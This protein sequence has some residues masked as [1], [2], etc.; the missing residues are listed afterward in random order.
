M[1]LSCRSEAR[2]GRQQGDNFF[3]LF[4]AKGYMVLLALNLHTAL[5]PWWLR[6]W[7]TGTKAFARAWVRCGLHEAERGIYLLAAKWERLARSSKT[8]Q[9]DSLH[10]NEYLRDPMAAMPWLA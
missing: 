6:D 3:I 8:G 2:R 7:R 10:F 1:V 4:E 9:N 5:R